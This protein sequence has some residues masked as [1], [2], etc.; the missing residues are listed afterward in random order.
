M[1]RK[2]IIRKIAAVLLVFVFMQ[3]TGAG[4][5]LHNVL[6]ASSEK[7]SLPDEDS[8]TGLSYACSCVDDFLLPFEETKEPVVVHPILVHPSS[9]TFYVA[10]TSYSIDEPLSLRGPPADRFFL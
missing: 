8:K 3:K 6:H 1:Q 7:I 10:T 4:L 5:F 9:V 2:T